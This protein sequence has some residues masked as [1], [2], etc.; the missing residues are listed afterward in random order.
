MILCGKEINECSV[1]APDDFKV[2]WR[3]DMKVEDYHADK[4][5]VNSSSLKLIKKSA[6][7]FARTFWIK[8]KDATDAMKFGTLVHMAI[9]EPYKFKNNYHVEPTFTLFTKAGQPT[10]SKNSTDYTNKYESWRSELPVGAIIVTQDEQDKIFN[11]IDSVLSHPS[12]GALLINVK[13][14]LIGYWKKNVGT[15]EKPFW[16]A[17]RLMVDAMAFS[18]GTLADLKTCQ[19]A[20]WEVFRKTHV[21]GLDACHQMAMY[22]DGTEAIE[23]AT[24]DNKAWIAV[25][26]VWPHETMVHEVHEAYDMA[27]KFQFNENL[28]KLKQSIEEKHFAFGQPDALKGEPSSWFYKDYQLKGAY[29]GI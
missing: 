1:I 4:A 26:S 9:L 6:Y 5:A 27:G 20:S 28:K 12:A 17:L 29:N 10:T 25:E 22:T 24:V 7:S 14:E 11:M 21:E 13:P 19:N 3:E 2:G 23:K 8:S 18:L 16:I 15:A